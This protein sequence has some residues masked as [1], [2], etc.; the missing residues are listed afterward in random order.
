MKRNLTNHNLQNILN[1]G[2]KWI[3]PEMDDKYWI[4]VSLVTK[5][6]AGEGSLQTKIEKQV[7]EQNGKE[8]DKM[9]M[10]NKS[11]IQGHKKK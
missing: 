8:N 11:Y 5:A 2:S 10:A 4:W 1:P 3:V 6:M 9:K 7:R